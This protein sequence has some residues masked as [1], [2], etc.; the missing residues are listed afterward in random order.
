MT[1]TVKQGSLILASL[2]KIDGEMF[3][4]YTLDDVFD[5]LYESIDRTLPI[6]DYGFDLPF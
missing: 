4:V 2:Y 6:E 3:L 1:F 5:G